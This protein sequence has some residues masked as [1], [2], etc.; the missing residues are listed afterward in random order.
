MKKDECA[1]IDVLELLTKVGEIPLWIGRRFKIL[2]P[3]LLWKRQGKGLVG[4]R[5]FLMEGLRKVETL[6]VQSQ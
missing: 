3:H 1:R 5:S 2:T 6:N 4:R